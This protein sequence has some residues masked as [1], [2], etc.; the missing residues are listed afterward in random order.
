[1]KSILKRIKRIW[2]SMK[3]C[4]SSSCRVETKDNNGDGI[5][6]E[7]NIRRKSL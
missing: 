7:I 3:C 2:C 1:M 4:F 5:P 6:D